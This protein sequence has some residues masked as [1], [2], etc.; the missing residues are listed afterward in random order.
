[1]GGVY[2]AVKGKCP[3]ECTICKTQ[4]EHEASTGWESSQPYRVEYYCNNHPDRTVVRYL[5]GTGTK[6]MERTW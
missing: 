1:M 6:S 2:G 5:W 4:G 3:C